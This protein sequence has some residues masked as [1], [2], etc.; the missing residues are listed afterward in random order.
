MVKPGDGADWEAVSQAL[1]LCCGSRKG[2][3]LL[4]HRPFVGFNNKHLFWTI[5]KMEN[6]K[7]SSDWLSTMICAWNSWVSC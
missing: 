4:T 5:W 3:H 7:L 1:Q 6:N 2:E